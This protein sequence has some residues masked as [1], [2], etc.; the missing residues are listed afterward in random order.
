MVLGQFVMPVTCA[1]NRKQPKKITAANMLGARGLDSKN[2]HGVWII[3]EVAQ[4][5]GEEVLLALTIQLHGYEV[6]MRT[7]AIIRTSAGGTLASGITIAGMLVLNQSDFGITP[8]SALGGALVVKD[9]V[10]VRFNI[11]L[12]PP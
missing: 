1:M 10:E 11:T 2:H 4:A 8:F 7:P 3:G 5:S 9:R 6:H 12:A